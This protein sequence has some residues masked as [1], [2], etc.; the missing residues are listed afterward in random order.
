[1]N[2]HEAQTPTPLPSGLKTSRCAAC[3]VT[4]TTPG[5]FDK[6]QL[7]GGPFGTLCRDPASVGLVV[8]RKHGETPIWGWPRT[9][10]GPSWWGEQEEAADA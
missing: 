10:E 5:A 4:F 1:M 3:S 2:G 6:H 9:G 7:S 8:V